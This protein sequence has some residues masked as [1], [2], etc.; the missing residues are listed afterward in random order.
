MG[1]YSVPT[2]WLFGYL[3]PFAQAALVINLIFFRPELSILVWGIV[4]ACIINV[5][6]ISIMKFTDS[7]VQGFADKVK[8]FWYGIVEMVWMQFFY[9]AVNLKAAFDAARGKRQWDKF[10][11]IGFNIDNSEDGSNSAEAPRSTN[12]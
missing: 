9:M 11:R 8:L 6:T 10:D 4:V 1:F 5:L 7:P 3:A 12:I 2:Y